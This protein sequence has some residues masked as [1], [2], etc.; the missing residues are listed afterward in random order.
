MPVKSPTEEEIRQA[1]ARC[2]ALIQRLNSL[3][4]RIKFIQPE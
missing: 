1:I 3:G 4:Y 2:N